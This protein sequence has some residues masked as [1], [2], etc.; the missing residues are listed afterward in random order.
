ML[1]EDPRSAR[2]RATG[3]HSAVVV[4]EREVVDVRLILVAVQTRDG[5]WAGDPVGV[6]A[7]TGFVV[8]VVA[9]PE[10]CFGGFFDVVGG[11]FLSFLVFVLA[12][13]LGSWMGWMSDLLV[14]FFWLV[15][16]SQSLGGKPWIVEGSLVGGD[17]DTS[18]GS[19]AGAGAAE[20]MDVRARRWKRAVICMVIRMIARISLIFVDEV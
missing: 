17:L 11:E 8:A 18:P 2:R 12:G 15:L 4:V 1:I 5:V 13:R 14:S 6:L 16:H 19:E 10:G 9:Q 20:T 7:A 3:K